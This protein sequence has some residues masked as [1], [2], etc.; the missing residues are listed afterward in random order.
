MFLPVPYPFTKKPC[1]KIEIGVTTIT[2]GKDNFNKG[3]TKNLCL[4]ISKQSLTLSKQLQVEMV[5]SEEKVINY[6]P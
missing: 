3:A 5:L 6:L 2:A 1:L 4:C